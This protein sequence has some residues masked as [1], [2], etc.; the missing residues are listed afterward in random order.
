MAEDGDQSE[1]APEYKLIHFNTRFLAEP[2][3]F[4]F[5]QASVPF[6]DIRV[7]NEEW[8]DMKAG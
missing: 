1:G 2:I 8:Y 4:V 5:I 3:R 6:Q 7:T